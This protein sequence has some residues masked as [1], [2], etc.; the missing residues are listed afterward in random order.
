V[1]SNEGGERGSGGKSERLNVHVLS[2]TQVIDG[3]PSMGGI[4]EAGGAGEGTMLKEM[5][6]PCYATSWGTT[7]VRAMAAATTPVHIVFFISFLV[8]ILLAC[9]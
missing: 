4:S 7:V 6:S 2:G 9:E 3:N 5:L 8:V 1:L